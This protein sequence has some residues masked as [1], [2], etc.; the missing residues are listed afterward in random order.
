MKRE[1]LLHFY[2]FYELSPK[3]PL[4]QQPQI[5]IKIQSG[6]LSVFWLFL[7]H[8]VWNCASWAIFISM[9]VILSADPVQL[10]WFSAAFPEAHRT[11]QTPAPHHQSQQEG[12]EEI[13][14]CSSAAWLPHLSDGRCPLSCFIIRAHCCLENWAG[15]CLTC[16]CWSFCE[17]WP[18]P[19]QTLRGL[20]PCSWSFSLPD[21][22]LGPSP[23]NSLLQWIWTVALVLVKPVC[24]WPAPLWSPD[25]GVFHPSYVVVL[26]I[27][28]HSSQTP[29]G[30]LFLV[31]RL[32]AENEGVSGAMF[33]QKF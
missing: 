14:T 25:P 24:L 3:P 28:V 15:L 18:L 4:Q 33:P 13:H 26:T 22:P 21:G 12:R 29:V 9:Q 30:H 16:P 2:K 11:P 31:L 17:Y 1:M 32:E 27:R 10:W 5:I 8:F 19:P 7:S 23:V 20:S 6:K